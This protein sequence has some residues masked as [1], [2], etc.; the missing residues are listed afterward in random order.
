MEGR[1]IELAEMGR[2]VWSNRPTAGRTGVVSVI[3]MLAV[4]SILD[5]LT[6]PVNPVEM[7][8]AGRRCAFR[9][10]HCGSVDSHRGYGPLRGGSASWTRGLSN[11]RLDQVLEQ[12]VLWTLEIKEQ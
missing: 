5:C 3:S 10:S 2:D 4:G 11:V 12:S 6:L 9:Q 8:N 1:K 7:V